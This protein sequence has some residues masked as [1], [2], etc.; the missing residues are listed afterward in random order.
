MRIVSPLR[1][2][3]RHVIIQHAAIASRPGSTA[4]G[5]FQHACGGYRDIEVIRI[6]RVNDDGMDARLEHAIINA[7][8]RTEPAVL[9][10]RLAGE[11]IAAAAFMIP[12]RPVEFPAV[13]AIIADEQAA[14]DR[15]GIQP[16]GLL[17][18]AK[19]KIPDLEY[20][21]VLVFRLSC[22]RIRI[23]IRRRQVL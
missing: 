16:A 6:A 22:R 20:G 21:C 10:G 9:A 23:E 5:G 13:A 11:Q 3:V 4:I 18:I 14:G 1:F 15:A 2:R 19:R 7:R 12:Q 8:R 17:G